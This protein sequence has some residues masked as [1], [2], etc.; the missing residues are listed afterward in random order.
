MVPW[1]GP[2][3]G[4]LVDTVEDGIERSGGVAPL[5]ASPGPGWDRVARGTVEADGDLLLLIDP[6]ALI[7]GPALLEAA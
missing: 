1:G 2:T 7:A 3:G 6:H 5:R 4:R